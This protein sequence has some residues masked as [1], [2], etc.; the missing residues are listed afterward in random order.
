MRRDLVVLLASN[1]QFAFREV[2]FEVSN[3]A[4]RAT[5]D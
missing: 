3:S 4:P 2:P 5:T 1:N